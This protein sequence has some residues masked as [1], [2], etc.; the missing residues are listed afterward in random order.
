MLDRA[1]ASPASRRLGACAGPVAADRDPLMPL[2]F[3]A[4]AD[5]DEAARALAES[6]IARGL[7]VSGGPGT[8]GL[9]LGCGPE[10]LTLTATGPGGALAL[11]LDF[12][13]GRQGYRLAHA[14]MSR[15]DLVRALGR[16]P[17]DSTIL[18]GSAGLGRDSLVLAARGFRVIAL[19]RHPVL[20]ALLADAL[21][22][23]SAHPP[24]QPVLGRLEFLQADAVQWLAANGVKVDAA[25]FDPMFPPR[26]KD[27]AVKKEMQVLYH[28]L[29]AN[30]DPDAPA[31]LAV[32]R[33][34]VRRR[35]VVKRPLHA[36]YLG[37]EAPAHE[38]RG[39]STR[40]DIYLPTDGD[41]LQ[42]Q[43]G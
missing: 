40:F 23:A 39:R 35:V 18:D 37:G 4:T 9:E 25:V 10:G 31:T 26:A 30:A 15:E 22:R 11:H 14:G 43:P 5:C 34:H 19:E 21:A 3:R 8:D 28:L 42:S 16:L 20:G 12:V 7:A 24:L 17:R 6:L 29:G 41:D 38:L 32:L 2:T 27:A 1:G 33:R 13:R 36:P